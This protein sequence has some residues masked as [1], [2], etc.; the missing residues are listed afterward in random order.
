MKQWDHI[1]II[2]SLMIG[3]L[4]T[5]GT[6]SLCLLLIQWVFLIDMWYAILVNDDVMDSCLHRWLKEKPTKPKNRRKGI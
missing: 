1:L 6:L 5:S 2:G 3:V 4:G